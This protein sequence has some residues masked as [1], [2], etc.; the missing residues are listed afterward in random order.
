MQNR[1]LGPLPRGATG[2]ERAALE[3]LLRQ[4]EQQRV[5]GREKSLSAHNIALEV[6]LSLALGTLWLSLAPFNDQDTSL[7]HVSALFQFC[8]AA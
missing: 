2:G 6:L 3:T 4:M 1:P 7:S 8:R 5:G